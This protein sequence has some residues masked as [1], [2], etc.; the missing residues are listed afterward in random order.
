MVSRTL[1]KLQNVAT[2]IQKEFKV[3]TSVIAVDF[4]TPG[5]SIYETI[6]NEIQ[7]KEIGILV[8]NV[9]MA[10][11]EWDFF[12]QIPD[13]EK[14]IQDLIQ[15]NVISVP[16]MC[17][18]ILPQMVDRKRGL[19]INLSSTAAVVPTP[20]MAVYAGTKA[21]VHKFSEDLAM[22]YKNQGI[23][24]QSVLPGPVATPLI[25]MDEG[26]ILAPKADVYVNS[27][28]KTVESTSYTAGYLLH[29]LSIIVSAQLLNFLSPAIVRFI[30]LNR[31]K[32]EKERAI[33][34]EKS[35]RK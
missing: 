7:G 23:V 13:L 32:S 6:K 31:N 27:A 18:I 1:S 25:K 29:S 10:N 16:M 11:P 3:E 35:K 28:I 20:L 15:C 24:I 33:Q 17:S 4:T 14:H 26:N 19:V 2:E 12:L 5:I 9:G 8:N 22:E 21:F 34:Y 30:V